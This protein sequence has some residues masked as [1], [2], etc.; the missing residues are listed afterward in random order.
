MICL[1]NGGNADND[2]RGVRKGIHTS[3]EAVQ[4]HQHLQVD[5]LALGSLAVA[6]AHMVTVQ[7]DT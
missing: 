6:V 7:V 4:L 3:E 2:W 1:H 5:I